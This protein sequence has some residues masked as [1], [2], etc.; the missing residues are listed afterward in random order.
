MSWAIIEAV[1]ILD[2]LIFG[3]LFYYFF[4]AMK[5]AEGEGR[6]VIRAMAILT[7]VLALQELYFGINTL[8]DPNKLAVFSGIYPAVN[9]IWLLAKL[10]LTISGITIIYTLLRMKK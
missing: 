4:N 6:S 10:I 7:G 8:T 5:S 3:F 1:Y 2:V 9:S